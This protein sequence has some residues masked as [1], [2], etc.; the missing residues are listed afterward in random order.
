MDRLLLRNSSRNRAFGE[1]CGS[2][3]TTSCRLSNPFISG[4][5]YQQGVVEFF[6]GKRE[7]TKENWAK[8]LEDFNKLGG[9]DWEKNGIALAKENR[10][11]K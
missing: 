9:A 4:S 11:I 1:A 2:A 7:L 6:T 5:F 3:L 10:F 8:F